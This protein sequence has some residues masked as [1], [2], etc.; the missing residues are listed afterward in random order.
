MNLAIICIIIGVVIYCYRKK[1]RELN[2]ASNFNET[3]EFHLKSEVE[4]SKEDL[5]TLVLTTQKQDKKTIVIN[6]D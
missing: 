2:K 6:A 1:K 5:R 4:K 3:T